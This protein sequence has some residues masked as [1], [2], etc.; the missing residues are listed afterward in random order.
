MPHAWREREDTALRLAHFRH[1][2]TA[3]GARVSKVGSGRRPAVGAA[4]G[5]EGAEHTNPVARALAGAINAAWRGNGAPPAPDRR[6]G[7][8][9]SPDGQIGAKHRAPPNVIVAHQEGGIEVIHLYSGKTLC[10]MAMPPGGPH[11]DINGDG[12]V[13]HVQ[14]HGSGVDAGHP[15]TA[16]TANPRPT[17][18]RRPRRGTRARTPVRGKR[19]GEA[20]GW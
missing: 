4:G 16:R 8:G 3:K 10:K 13:D 12:V 14:A 2:R 1:H 20:R 6:G 9:H 7:R 11:A 17:A 18:G 5:A 15:V 19:A